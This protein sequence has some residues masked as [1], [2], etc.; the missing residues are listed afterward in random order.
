MTVVVTRELKGLS[1]Q[2]APGRERLEPV[3]GRRTLTRVAV[4]GGNVRVSAKAG[5]SLPDASGCQKGLR[6]RTRACVDQPYSPN[7]MT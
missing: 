4:F 5:V 3:A 6:F 2:C 7:S 1:A